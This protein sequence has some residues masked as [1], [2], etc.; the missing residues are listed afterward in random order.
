M[1]TT[2]TIT[3]PHCGFFK[4]VGAD[5]LPQKA[6]GVTCP[7]CRERFL[8]T[9]A[10]TGEAIPAP[11]R[12]QAEPSSGPLPAEAGHRDRTASEPAAATHT[13]KHSLAQTTV[14]QGGTRAKTLLMAFVLLVLALVALRIWTDGKARNIPFPNFLAASEERVAVSWGD[15][16]YVL[17][18]AGRILE[19]QA[20][21]R[22]TILTQMQ[23]IGHELWIGNYKAKSVQRVANGSLQ[24]VLDGS[25]KIGGTFKF[26]ADKN[27]GQIFVTDTTNHRVH[28]FSWGGHLLKTFGAQG[29]GPGQLMFPNS[30]VFRDDGNLLIVNTNAH[31]FDV[32]SRNGDFV[33]T[34][35]RVEGQGA[36]RFPT[37]LSQSGER[38]AALLTIDLLRARAVI[39]STDGSYVGEMPPPTALEE[40]GDVASFDDKVL[41]T[42]NKERK[43][44][45]FSAQTLAYLGPFS[46]DLDRIGAEQSKAASRYAAVSRLSLKALLVACIPV[47]LLFFRVRSEEKR[48]VEEFDYHE[49]V[50]P[51]VIWAPETRRDKLAQGMFAAVVALLI[52][53]WGVRYLKTDMTV[54]VICHAVGFVIWGGAIWLIFE[55]GY[56]NPGR[57]EAVDRLVRAAAVNL[58]NLLHAGE[59]VEGCT[60]LQRAGFP[61][62]PSMFLMTGER[63]VIVDF[64]GGRPRRYRQV[65]YG[66]VCAVTV[67]KPV[68]MRRLLSYFNRLRL[69][70]P[71]GGHPGFVEFIAQDGGTPLRVARYLEERRGSGVRS[72]YADLCARCFRPLET[73]GTC[74]L[75]APSRKVGR[76]PLA[77]SLIYPGLGQFYNRE[78]L[79]GTV[80]AVVFTCGILFLTRPVMVLWEGSAEVR[81]GDLVIVAGTLILLCLCYVFGAADADYV[82][83]KGRQLLSFETLRELLARRSKG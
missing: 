80:L 39:Y 65:G 79:K 66:D 47:F 36:Y 6:T 45:Q 54:A 49:S 22:D 40:V 71:P 27:A 21:P 15:E 32:F 2:I 31:R 37:L 59:T 33:K 69:S 42:D 20:L 17:D 60:V 63:L 53:Q 4:E 9:P 67:N 26:A 19:K 29:K 55:S 11:S 50:P 70:L 34:L 48:R 46:A 61:V 52:M 78:I 56:R 62:Q 76:L 18:H 72:G 77:L 57:R 82:G 75:C 51:S 23:F 74:A 13:P 83:R 64:A 58:P 8:F 12:I 7:K 28:L 14:G 44:Y 10:A 68:G 1:K 38:M 81:D 35:A 41:I 5:K 73:D 25:G 3:C 16:I 24:T 30:I 43:V